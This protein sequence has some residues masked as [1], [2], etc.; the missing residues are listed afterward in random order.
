MFTYPL[1]TEGEGRFLKFKEN[2]DCIFLNRD[3]GTY[4]CQIYEA[5]PK[6]CRDYP[7]NKKQNE[8]CDINRKG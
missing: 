2:G 4:L 8:T 5:R 6:I 3:E 7:S 1:G